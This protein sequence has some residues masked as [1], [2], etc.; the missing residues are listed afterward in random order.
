MHPTGKI[1]RLTVLSAN[2]VLRPL[3]RMLVAIACCASG[4]SIGR[5]AGA[6]AVQSGNPAESRALLDKL[7]G[8]AR[9][10]APEVKL[11]RSALVASR[12]S[13]ARAR[14]APIE[15]PLV[16]V[17]VDRGG[18]GVTRDVTVDASLWLPVELS[19]QRPSRRREAT[20]YVRL[21]QA[22]LERARAVATGRTVRAFGALAVAT[23]RAHVLEE[24]L[25]VSRAESDYYAARVAAGDATERD[26]AFAALETARHEALLS[27]TRAE[28]VESAGE[29]FELT[30]WSPEEGRAFDATLPV[31]ALKRPLAAGPLHT[32]ATTALEQRARYH[33]TT[34]ERLGREAWP[35]LGVGVTGGRGDY[36]EPRLGAG[37]T[38]AFPLFR[39][40]QVERAEAQAER[41]RTLDELELTRRVVRQRVGVIER[42]LAA[43]RES[44]EVLT[45]RALPA[46]NRAVTAAVETQRAGKGDWLAVLVSR[47]ELSALSL[48][49][50]EL[51]AKGWSLL[52][53]LS[54][55]TGEVP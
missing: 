51:L 24:L 16:E 38:Y 45:E 33:Q 25:N 26:A 27:E 2:V 32:P 1:G 15:N 21:H 20:A 48:R 50:L 36:G 40:N 28:V 18:H 8:L 55:M 39:A 9:E 54:E 41:R 23:K 22:R 5:A 49:R 14:L 37:L 17:K 35:A 19:G 52:G 30:G 13:Y 46:A 34:F 53:E 10:H 7:V 6:E 11:G 31:S 4:L 3:F 42:E 47:R 29:L 44:L 12:S 43:L